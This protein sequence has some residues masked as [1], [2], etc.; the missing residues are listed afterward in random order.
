[1]AHDDFRRSCPNC[2]GEG[3]DLT[4]VSP[5]VPAEFWLHPP[6]RAA[7]ESRHM[8]RVVAAYRYNPWHRP[9][10]GQPLVASWLG[11]NQS[12]LSR[13]E[14][15][16]AP[17]DLGRL[18]DVAL[19]LQIPAH[20]LWFKLPGDNSPLNP[21]VPV[22]ATPSEALRGH[23]ARSA[24]ESLRVAD[25]VAALSARTD[26]LD[27]ARGE[28]RR[29][30][31]AY[32]HA[33][34]STVFHELVEVRDLI[35]SRVER[36]QRPDSARELY[37]LGGVACLLLAHACHNSGDQSAAFA[38]LA[39]ASAV[40]TVIEHDALNAWVLGTSAL[41]HEWSS[42]P[43]MALADTEHGLHL[44]SSAQSRIRLS[45]IEARIAARLGDRARAMTALERIDSLLAV[46]DIDDDITET[47]GLLSFPAAKRTYYRGSVHGLLGESDLAEQHAR[48]AITAYS[49]GDPDQ[50]SYGDEALAWVDVT[51]A[52]LGHEDVDGAHRAATAVLGLAPELRIRQ[53]DTAIGRTRAL[54]V[55]LHERGHGAAGAFAEM[56]GAYLAGIIAPEKGGTARGARQGRARPP[57]ARPPHSRPRPAS[58]PVGSRGRCRDGHWR[59]RTMDLTGLRA[60]RTTAESPTT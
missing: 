38:H 9:P 35:F 54:A 10:L 34:V 43:S 47:G 21:A 51:N 16:A 19:L 4:V 17:Q 39:A 28:L 29:I 33:P 44:R 36:P 14:S 42:Q 1:L 12:V 31:V 2:A 52:R 56:L 45:A 5:K 11:L 6:L 49:A 23:M 20:L 40:A 3:R 8:G 41:I 46:E 22:R 26:L 27:Y 24:G 30:A 59:R 60:S 58:S 53:V 37:V 32:V 18:I 48:A 13:M 55:S 50:R 15:G 25:E 57:R 7:L